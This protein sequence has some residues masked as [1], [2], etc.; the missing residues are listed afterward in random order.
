MAVPTLGATSAPPKLAPAALKTIRRLPAQHEGRWSPLDTVA[1]DMVEQVTGARRWQGQDPVL[2]LLDWTFRPDVYSDQ[3][4]I[5][6]GSAEVRRLLGLPADR[7]R[8]SISYLQGHPG[9]NERLRS[10]MQKR[11]QG[12]KTDA[13][14][15]KVEDIAG[16]MSVL[17]RVLTGEVI[18][19]VPHPDDPRGRWMSILRVTG[20]DADQITRVKEGWQAVQSSFLAGDGAGLDAAASGLTKSLAAL[21]TAHRPD[22][23]MIALE[24]RYNTLDPFR[25]S[26]ILAAVGA[27]LALIAIWVRRR[28]ADALVWAVSAGTFAMATA[29]LAMRWQL[30]ERIPAANMYESMVFMGW[31]LCLATMI[32]L[33]AVRDRLV[34]LLASLLAAISLMIADLVGLDPF[35][36]PIAPVLLDT[37][38]MAIHVPVIMVSYSILMISMGFALAVLGMSTAAPHRSDLIAATDHLHLRFIQVGVIL[39]T[40]GIVT[41]SMWGSASWGRYWGWDPKE[42]WSLIALLGYVAILHARATGWVRAYGTALSS[43]VAFWLIVMAYVGV[44]YVLGIGLHSYGFGKGAVV[45]WLMIIGGVQLSLTLCVVVIHG[46]RRWRRPHTPTGSATHA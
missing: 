22:P 38:W 17:A 46:V 2:T 36:R 3:P 34:T 29:G 33:I 11:R 31:G 6:V 27:G 30:A 7:D 37:A 24:V 40:T 1:R 21:K 45:R 19:P 25:W 44:N 12:A 18:R 9:L 5:R 20:H 42:V 26:W 28:S 35:L 32:C 41:G 4:L 13:L 15:G 14:D 43:T 8:F 23:E 10:A 16:A 39:L